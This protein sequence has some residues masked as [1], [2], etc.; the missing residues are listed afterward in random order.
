M[1]SKL[2]KVIANFETTLATKL[3]SG[4]VSGSLTNATDKNGVALP[5]GKYCMIVDRGTGDEEHLVFD[6]SGTAMTNIK[7][8][9]RQGVQTTGVQNTAGHRVGARCV[10]TDF[11][12]LKVIVD[13][14]NGVDTL[15]ADNPLKYDADPSFSDSKQIISKGYADTKASKVD[16]NNFQGQNDFNLS[17]NIPDATQASHPVTLAQLMAAALQGI[18]AGLL[19]G[20]FS[21]KR[22]GGV[23]SL[24]DNIYGKTYVFGYDRNGELVSF[25]DGSKKYS[26]ATSDGRINSVTQ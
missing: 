2:T 12:N 21:L 18:P 13:I 17:P 19:E 8:V 7:S 20:I 10:L 22:G 3:S 6:L 26:I 24:H 4:A 5:A 15:D 1:A 16:A 9:S 11:I 25:Y 23:R 14:L